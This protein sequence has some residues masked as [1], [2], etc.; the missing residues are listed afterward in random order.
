MAVWKGKVEDDMDTIRLEADAA[1]EMSEVYLWLTRHRGQVVELQTN[2]NLTLGVPISGARAVIVAAVL[3]NGVGGVLRAL[4]NPSGPPIRLVFDIRAKG[5]LE[6]DE[7]RTVGAETLDAISR[8]IAG[9]GLI[10]QVA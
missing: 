4:S 1:T 8:Q 9:E 2:R 3:D 5:G 6:A 7:V 10:T